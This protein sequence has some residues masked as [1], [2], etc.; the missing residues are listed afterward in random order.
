MTEW[1]LT[2]FERSLGVALPADYRSFVVRQNGGEPKPGWLIFPD[3]REVQVARL[4][5]IAGAKAEHFG[6]DGVEDTLR[7]LRAEHDL[8]TE[9]IP[10]G[11][12]PMKKGSKPYLF[13]LRVAGG[14]CGQ[15][16]FWERQPGTRQML[17]TSF[18]SFLDRLEFPRSTQ[19]WM[20]SIFQG[21]H[22]RLRHW[23]KN[24]GDPRAKHDETKASPLSE[25]VAERRVEIVKLLLDNGAKVGNALMQAVELGYGD[26]ARALLDYSVP[27]RELEKVYIVARD[28][29]GSADEEFVRLLGRRVQ[30][31]KT[32]RRRPEKDA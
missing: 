16:E 32:R 10:I 28:S 4:L 22:E 13:L 11:R 12:A 8:P 3:G 19:P 25:A 6:P 1:H 27:D 30:S 20:E 24:G 23:L 17:A 14:Q 7:E 18:Q 21:D 9:A 26:I 5:S 29:A 2:A 15:V 31:Q